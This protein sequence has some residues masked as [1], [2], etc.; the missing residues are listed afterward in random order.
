MA[1]YKAMHL[2]NLELNDRAVLTR[3]KVFIKIVFI[4]VFKYIP[5]LLKIVIL[6][7]GFLSGHL[8]RIAAI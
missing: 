2:W 1:L 4:L 7:A 6:A 8:A 3:K 5:K